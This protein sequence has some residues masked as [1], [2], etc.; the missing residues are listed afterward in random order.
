MFFGVPMLPIAVFLCLICLFDAPIGRVLGNRAFGWFIYGSC[1]VFGVLGMLL[2]DR[3]PPRLAAPLGTLGWIISFT[4][5][6]W[7]FWFGPGALN[8]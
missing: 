5:L 7:F 8:F 6:Y 2:Y 3:V 1:T 4:L